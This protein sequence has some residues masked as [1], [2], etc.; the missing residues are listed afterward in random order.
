MSFDLN[1]YVDV[2]ERIRIAKELYPE[3]SLQS[4]WEDITIDGQQYIVVKAVAYRSPSDDHPGIGHAWEPVPGKTSYTK[5]SEL[6]NGETS[7]W[8]RALAAL[9]IEVRKVASKQEVQSA[10]ARQETVPPSQREV[11]A[12]QE[13]QPVRG[14]DTVIKDP[15]SAPSEKQTMALV[16]KTVKLGINSDFHQQ[17]WQ[18]CLAGGV[19][20]GAEPI[21]KG[22]ASNL[23]GMDKADFEGYGASFFGSLMSAA[24]D[25]EAPF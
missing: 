18:Y 11:K 4:T 13:A 21:T 20:S 6:M 23:I 7:A 3:L 16:N 19:Q 5:G 2:A 1:D 22:Q 17:F 15:S 8:G 25:D 24:T 10:K 12:P 9:G 14:T